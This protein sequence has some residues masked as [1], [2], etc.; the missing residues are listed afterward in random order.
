MESRP[1]ARRFPTD[2]IE[3]EHVKKIIATFVGLTLVAAVGFA[4]DKPKAESDPIV[5]SAGDVTVHQSEFENALK[6]LPAEYKQYTVGPGR[7][8]FAEDYMRMKILAADG[9]KDGLDKD[10]DIIRQLDLIRQNLVANAE[11]HKIESAIEVPLD[12]LQKRYEANKDQ[13][14]HVKAKHILIAF[15]GS[16][17]AQQGKPELTEDE[18]KAKAEDLRKQI[19]A[20]ASFEDL[21]KK[22]SDDTGS[23]SRGGELGEFGHHQMVPEFEKAAFDAKVGEVTPVVRTQFGYHIIKVEA[24]DTTSFDDVKDTLEQQV[25]QELLKAKL[26]AMKEAA[27]IVFDDTYFGVP[28]PAKTPETPA[29]PA[30]NPA[31]KAKKP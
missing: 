1:P 25:R 21:A 29:P 23:G 16:P 4:Q 18:A 17:A 19:V 14:E 10:P 3:G 5:I 15:K 11:I 24:H 9:L 2:S 6:T 20:G 8:Q 22:E 31:P 28:A 27:K 7:K 13:Y 26:D 30:T 12:E